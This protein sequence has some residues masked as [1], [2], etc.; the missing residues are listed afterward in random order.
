MS[1]KPEMLVG[2]K[3]CRNALC[4]AT[5][6][7]AE[8]QALDLFMRWTTPKDHR[9]VESDDPVTHTYVNGQLDWI[10]PSETPT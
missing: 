10:K 6:E 7:E 8:Q 1:F 5:K 3:W 4:F 9:A 2:D